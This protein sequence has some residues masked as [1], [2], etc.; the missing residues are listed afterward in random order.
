MH[1]I[2]VIGG[3]SWAST[4]HFLELLNKEIAGRLGGLHSATLLF[5]SLDLAQITELR[6]AGDWER[7]GQ[8][9][10]DC[11]KRLEGAGAD[12]L[13]MT[14]TSMHKLYAQ[15]TEAVGVPVLHVGDAVGERLAAEGRKRVG[16]LGTRLTMSEP[17]LRERLESHGIESILPEGQWLPELDRIIYDELVAGRVVRDSQR[18]LKTLI[19]ELS[20]QKVQAIVLASADLALDVDTRANILPVYDC[21]AIHAQAA[22][23]WMTRE[24]EAGVRE[25]A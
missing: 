11:A 10:V 3:T 25:A 17:Y 16:L 18:K 2:G 4:G 7:V 13:L 23:Q 22:A 24:A 12:G 8:L 19:T 21:T 20:R 14:S 5:E 1:K 15:I 6:L 9:A